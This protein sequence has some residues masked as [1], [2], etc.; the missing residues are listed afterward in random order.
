MPE[1]RKKLAQI[2]FHKILE[3]FD[4]GFTKLKSNKIL[5]NKI[6]RPFLVTNKLLLAETVPLTTF[7]SVE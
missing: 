4:V 1:A 2:W 6:S 3:T 7:I 5:L